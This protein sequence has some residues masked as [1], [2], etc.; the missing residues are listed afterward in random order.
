MFSP[1]NGQFDEDTF[2]F[3]IF[4]VTWGNI[5]SLHDSDWEVCWRL[6]NLGNLVELGLGGVCVED[7]GDGL[8]VDHGGGEVSWGSCPTEG[9]VGA[10]SC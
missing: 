9:V 2:D 5:L 1:R 4:F 7:G 10:G 8:P 6:G 3:K